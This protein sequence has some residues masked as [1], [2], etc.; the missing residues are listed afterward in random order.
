MV[1]VG[2]GVGL[3]DPMLSTGHG[4]STSKVVQQGLAVLK[5]DIYES[6]KRTQKSKEVCLIFLNTVH[7]LYSP[8]CLPVPVK[9]AII[10]IFVCKGNLLFCLWPK[11]WYLFRAKSI[12]SLYEEKFVQDVYLKFSKA[13]FMLI[14]A[15][16]MACKSRSGDILAHVIVRPDLR[17]NNGKSC[18]SEAGDLSH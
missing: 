9:N 2:Q 6:E 17:K 18:E 3:Q 11:N 16:C 5:S 1:S 14:E 15:I 7:I 12:N 13:G 8:F 4:W 10:G